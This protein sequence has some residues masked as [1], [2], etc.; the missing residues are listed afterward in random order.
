MYIQQPSS[1]FLC[2]YEITS[3]VYNISTVVH[4]QCNLE[5]HGKSNWSLFGINEKFACSAYICISGRIRLVLG[6]GLRFG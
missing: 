1:T 2:V 6:Q 3:I 4:L 5:P